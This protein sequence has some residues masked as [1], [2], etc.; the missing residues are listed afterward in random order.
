MEKR[1]LCSALSDH[2]VQKGFS[3]N[4]L[5]L[6]GSVYTLI[7]EE[8]WTPL[9][10]AREFSLLL[11]ATGRL[12]K[13]GLGVALC[14]GDRSSALEEAEMVLIDYRRTIT[15][16]LSWLMEKPGRIEELEGIYVV[17]G[18]EFIKE[19][20][21]GTLSSILSTSMPNPT[22][23]IIAYAVVPGSDTVKISARTLE[24]L[25]TRGLDLGEILRVAAEKFEG[26]GGGHNIAAGAQL[27]MESIDSFIKLANE[28]TKKQVDQ[29]ET[30]S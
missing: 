22:K 8:P 27:P 5:D 1:K 2:M 12:E 20:L 7:D 30:K 23:P 9:R 16:Y 29:I 26:E 28:M 6:I 13:A 21:I 24:T 19:K 18:G 17:R 11:N 4:V 10:D 25:T 3:D 14:M 15:N